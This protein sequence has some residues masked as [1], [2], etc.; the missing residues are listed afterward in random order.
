M[1]AW[2]TRGSQPPFYLKLVPVPKLRP[3]SWK[4]NIKQWDHFLLLTRW[5]SNQSTRARPR[6]VSYGSIESTST[7]R[8]P[9][10]RH[11]P[12]TAS[13][14]TEGSPFFQARQG[15]SRNVRTIRQFLRGHFLKPA[16]YGNVL[17][18]SFRRKLDRYRCR[19]LHVNSNVSHLRHY[20]R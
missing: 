16:R 5:G 11:T 14:P 13:N 6:S 1:I 8:A 18:K 19:T 9:S 3:C 12:S 7:S 4:V 15:G 10:T 17:A 2:N 20:T